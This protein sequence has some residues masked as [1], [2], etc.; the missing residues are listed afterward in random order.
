MEQVVFDDIAGSTSNIKIFL[1]EVDQPAALLV[2]V[3][4]IYK[5]AIAVRIY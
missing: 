3:S 4:F 2:F 1:S 5:P